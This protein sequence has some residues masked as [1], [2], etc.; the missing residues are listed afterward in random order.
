LAQHTRQIVLR[1]ALEERGSANLHTSFTERQGHAP[2]T[3]DAIPGM[4]PR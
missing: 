3:T 1:E 2:D 4:T